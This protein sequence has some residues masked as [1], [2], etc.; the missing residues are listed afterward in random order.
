[1]GSLFTLL[2]STW[3][4]FA[5]AVQHTRIE[6]KPVPLNT[7][8]TIIGEITLNY[9]ISSVRV[10]S[11]MYKSAFTTITSTKHQSKYKVMFVDTVVGAATQLLRVKWQGDELSVCLHQSGNNHL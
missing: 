6:R 10:S 11:E 9:N 2:D 8:Q 3:I 4:L 7:T 5:V 1:M